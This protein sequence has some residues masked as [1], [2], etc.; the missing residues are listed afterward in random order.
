MRQNGGLGYCR[1]S[2]NLRE[3]P[4]QKTRVCDAAEEEVSQFQLHIA[5]I[6]M[7]GDKS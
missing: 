6:V 7:A 2:N 4:S 1:V 5:F 3:V